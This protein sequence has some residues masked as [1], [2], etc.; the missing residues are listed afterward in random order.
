VAVAPDGK[1]AYVVNNGDNSVSQYT[2]N[3][4]TGDLSP[5]SP[6]TVPAGSE[7]TAI[8]LSPDSMSAYVV[9]P[10]DNTVS[11]YDIASATGALSPKA[12]ATVSAGLSPA[13]LAVG[14]DADVSVKVS[15]PVSI[16]RGAQM[17]YTINVT[18]LGPSP[19]WQV[20]L[21]DRLPYGTQVVNAS[22]TGGGCTAPTA[23]TKGGT[24]TC[25]LGTVDPRQSA[26]I[27]RVKVKVTAGS[28]QGAVT[29]VA[30]VKSVTPDPV[31]NNNSASAKT[32][33]GG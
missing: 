20:T 3:P 17:T 30:T 29:D 22:T 16:T 31:S 27:Q 5:M 33:V 25:K 8:A 11:Q 28:N 9:N 13:G 4:S 21:S 1:S 26:G 6:A 19:A 32:K 12:P 14:P 2:I 7:P 24:L 15:A 10:A 23:G 18:N